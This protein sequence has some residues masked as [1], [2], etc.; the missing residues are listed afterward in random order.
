[1]F[2]ECGVPSACSTSLKTIYASFR[3]ASGYRATGLSTQSE[4][5][6]SACIVEL[7]SKPQVGK[8]AS[9][10][11][12]SNVF[13]VVFPRN[14]GTGFFPSSQMYSSLYFVIQISLDISRAKKSPRVY[15]NVG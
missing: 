4:L 15:Q 1:M 13:R 3:L 11:G 9:T 2:V 8:S 5:L 7:P 10:G 14:S 12:L 6:P